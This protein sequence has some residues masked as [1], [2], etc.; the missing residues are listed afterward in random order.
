MAN[1]KKRVLSL[2]MALV[3]MLGLLPTTA[4]AGELHAVGDSFRAE[5]KTAVLPENIPENT[6]WAGPTETPAARGTL[7]CTLQEHTHVT[8]AAC[9][10]THVDACYP[11]VWVACTR[12][13]NFDHYN[14]HGHKLGQGDYDWDREEY[15]TYQTSQDPDACPHVCSA[16]EGCVTEEMLCANPCPT[17]KHTHNA[18]LTSEKCCYEVIPA[19]YTWTLSAYQ[20]DSVSIQDTIATDGS[21]H[22]VVN[23]RATTYQWYKNNQLLDGETGD[24]LF[25]AKAESAD[26]TL[27]TYQV[28]ASVGTSSK[29]ASYTIPYYT[30]LQNG[31]FEK[32]KVTSGGPSQ[33]GTFDGMINQ[34]PNGTDSLIWTTTATDQRIEL[35]NPAVSSKYNNFPQNGHD[36]KQF[37]ELNAQAYGA[38]YQDIMTEP[39][40][41]LHWSFLHSGRGGA[42][43]TMQLVIGN[44]GGFGENWNP[45]GTTVPVGDGSQ[46]V[47][48]SAGNTWTYYH[49]DYVVPV[50]SYITRFYFNS[51]RATGSADGNLLDK[52]TFSTTRPEPP[53]DMLDY[54]IIYQVD[55][56][57]RSRETGSIAANRNAYP[58]QLESY[59]DYDADSKNAAYLTVTEAGPNVL[60]LRFTTPGYTVQYFI[61][62]GTAAYAETTAPSG[63]ST[64]G[65]AAYGAAVT[66][67]GL[68]LPDKLTVDAVTYGKTGVDAQLPATVSN[69]QPGTYT[70]TELNAQI[71]GYT[72]TP[73]SD[74]D[75]DSA[76]AGYQ[77][78]VTA[79][80][81]PAS[82]ALTN[83]YTSKEYTVIFDAAS[84]GQIKGNT[85]VNGIY[86]NRWSEFTPSEGEP[87]YGWAG[88]LN[89]NAPGSRLVYTFSYGDYLKY[90]GDMT[91]AQPDL[92]VA[93]GYLSDKNFYHGQDGY[94]NI[95][96]AISAMNAAE[97]TSITYAAEYARSEETP[98]TVHY[99]YQQPNGQYDE[100]HPTD[101]AARKGTTG[102]LAALT[103]ADLAAVTDKGM[104]YV[105]D[106]TVDHVR[107]A[108]DGSAVLKVYFKWQKT[109]AY[110]YEGG[111]PA[112]LAAHPLP[113]DATQYGAGAAVTNLG[114]AITDR[115]T[116]PTGAWSLTWNKTTDTMTA[117]GVTFLGTWTYT[118]NG[119]GTVTLRFV[120]E[121][122]NELRQSMTKTAP[123][124]T[125]YDFSAATTVETLEKDG[126]TYEFLSDDGAA[127]TGSVTER[128][129]TFTRVYAV[130]TAGVMLSKEVKGTD[131]LPANFTITVADKITNAAVAAL[132]LEGAERI[133]DGRWSW[134]FLLPVG[135]EYR[136]T[137]SGYNLGEGWSTVLTARQN[138]QIANNETEWQACTVTTD[139]FSVLVGG[140]TLIS[141]DRLAMIEMTNTYRYTAPILPPVID[142]DDDDGDDGY[143]DT[144]PVVIPDDPTPTTDLP[145][146]EVTDLPDGEVPLAEVP[147]TGDDLTMWIL[148]AAVSGLGL[149][150]LVISRKHGEENAK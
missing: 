48:T 89:A 114:T 51:T 144:P 85:V 21:L 50:N 119:S 96:A 115:A 92:L 66:G 79:G 82:I 61:R 117:D 143:P 29:R 13:N 4:F 12:E 39:G 112:I 62:T 47:F 125:A 108:G 55:G 91:I 120:D 65:K 123:S 139:A 19:F 30:A 25:V 32:P 64:S 9:T 52:I 72:L 97:V 70:V 111:T 22:A 57:E 76:K 23:G 74:V 58:S 71:P 136:F 121:S 67:A 102:E 84:Y 5:E 107:I 148:A 110:Q 83:I 87:Y 42:A 99:F 129:V 3:M 16:A 60:T 6:Y 131:T 38:L 134:F 149:V 8:A 118:P 86:T 33:V 113:A 142:D 81:T 34:F 59:Q 109:A 1:T 116:D 135:R 63:A 133:E 75:L 2:L 44:A 37:A 28:V 150:W 77:V 41:T 17:E 147:A 24:T 45:A 10:H 31:S 98:Y 132:T 36:G 26:T 88:T 49:G 7:I 15:G 100:A 141:S 105:L 35:V 20:V 68:T 94:Q 138:V 126:F 128:T 40:S 18:D 78:D 103:A 93:P 104:T 106:K 11:T 14:K 130:R 145:E 80:E 53:V 124:G 27:P 140:N 69:L 122:G 56:V 46:G 101:S 54:T 127:Y 137:E 90:T 43:N 95:A 73:V 146:E